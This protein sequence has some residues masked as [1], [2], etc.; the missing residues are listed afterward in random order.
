MD[1]LIQEAIL[2]LV[3][4]FP[5]AVGYYAIDVSIHAPHAERY[6]G[7]ASRPG[8]AVELGVA[9][10]ARR[11]GPTS[12]RWF[13]SPAAGSARRAWPHRG[14]LLGPPTSTPRLSADG[15]CGTVGG[16]T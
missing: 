5:A 3:I 13:S 2:D 9:E 1:G 10:K 8:L 14:R 16:L 11:Y 12:C 15:A 6:A 4:T 7:A